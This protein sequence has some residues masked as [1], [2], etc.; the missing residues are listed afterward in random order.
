MK[1]YSKTVVLG[2]LVN[3]VSGFVPGSTF[4]V[5]TSRISKTQGTSKINKTNLMSMV[6]DPTMID[7]S[8]VDTESVATSVSPVIQMIKHYS[9]FIITYGIFF[10]IL[11]SLRGRGTGGNP[12]N[13]L[14]ALGP[15]P[16]G[17]VEESEVGFDDVAGCDY[18]KKELEEV[19]DFMKNPDKYETY[20]AKL[21]RGILF[22]SQPG[23]GKTLMAKALAGESGVPLV[24]VSGS[25]FVSIFVGNGPK[26]VKEVYEMARKASPC[27]VFIDEIDSVASQ[28]GSSISGGGND[29]RE[30]TLNQLLTE[31]DGMTTDAT[32]ITIGATNRP[33]LLD[34][35]L[36]RPGRMD[37]RIELGSLDAKA[38]RAILDVHFKNKPLSSEV[39]L[40]AL[41][42]QTIGM[43]GA[44][45]ANIANEAA[46]LAARESVPEIDNS[47]VNM[48]FDK[49]TVGIRLLE[50]EIP[51]NTLNTVAYH[52]SGHALAS[53]LVGSPDRVSRISIVPSTSGAAGFTMFTP[54]EEGESGLHSKERLTGEIL[55]LLGGRAAEEIVFGDSHVTTGAYD[56]IRRAK[57]V[58]QNIVNDFGMGGNISFNDSDSRDK[59]VEILNESYVNILGAMGE[60]VELLNIIAEE[61]L[62]RKEISGE[63]FYEIME[64]NV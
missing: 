4:R 47:H 36:T 29:E 60:R 43:S 7:P 1:N 59:A 57:G 38:R 6:V 49:L 32:V 5:S 22:S 64:D 35:A 42:K 61:L 31:M 16:G 13:A 2:L 18:A 39:D 24:S 45:L 44:S 34:S 58:C 25:E 10:T 19:V 15:T 56:D 12:F 55:V 28:R 17:I 46:I 63:R 3:R 37:R 54:S 26:R 53:Y 30:A 51:T 41:S 23:M 20:G 62:E 21:P 52:E 11:Q 48:A 33:D 14:S 50:R 9:P 27:F 8:M 40:D